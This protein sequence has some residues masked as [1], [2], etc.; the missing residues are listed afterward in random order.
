MDDFIRYISGFVP[1]FP[2]RIQGASPSEISRLQQLVGRPLPDFYQAFLARMGRNAGGLSLGFD[3]DTSIL[4]VIDFYEKVIATKQKALPPHAIAIAVYGRDFDVCLECPSPEVER[5]LATEGLI[6]YAVLA[7]SLRKLLFQM[8]FEK[9]ELKH[10][11]SRQSSIANNKE[12]Q[13][14]QA[15]HGRALREAA[16][17]LAQELGFTPE[18][19]SDAYT[20]CARQDGV[21]VFIN[22]YDQQGLEVALGAE[23]PAL[24]EEM[25]GLFRDHLGL[26][27]AAR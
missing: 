7:E 25:S 18:W 17:E 24:V 14:H 26:R 12:A 2:Q 21:L 1:D 22:Q 11:P 9:H 6:V 15:T 27:P 10:C 16:R 19:F 13:A 8:V 4:E 5:V 20:F 3:T 23:E